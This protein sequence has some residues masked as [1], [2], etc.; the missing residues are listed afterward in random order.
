MLAFHVAPQVKR[1]RRVAVIISDALRFEVAEELARRLRREDKLDAKLDPILGVL[2][3][4]TQMGMAALLPHT[5]L[6][7]KGD[8][9]LTEVD[10]LR[11]DG[12]TYRGK[13]LEPFGGYAVQAEDVQGMTVH[14]LRDDL[15]PYKFVYV[16]GHRWLDVLTTTTLSEADHVVLVME[17]SVAHVNNAARLYRILTQQ[18]GIAPKQIVLVLNRYDKH[19]AVQ[20]DM[21]IKAV[22]CDEPF[23]L[24]NMY[25]L[26]LDSMN[27]AIPLFELDKDSQ[28]TRALIALGTHISG[29]EPPE[30][31][32]LFKRTLAA[33]T[34]RA[35]A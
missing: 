7:F 16:D 8:K 12:T 24:P 20:T 14:E 2:P 13:I 27:T 9:S 3:A 28:V 29:N 1:D 11:T 33:I 10:G 21:V 26:A 34:A 5:K 30:V 35:H 4:Y 6:G 25:E 15:K 18:L 32:G 19:A 31:P 23:K 17:Q 22:G